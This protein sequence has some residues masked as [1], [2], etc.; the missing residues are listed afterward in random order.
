MIHVVV[1]S[2]GQPDTT[3]SWRGIKSQGVV[4][5]EYWIAGPHHGGQGFGAML[6]RV[7]V[8]GPE[9]V[10]LRNQMTQRSHDVVGNFELVCRASVDARS[11]MVELEIYVT[12][13]FLDP[14]R[15]AA[16]ALGS[17]RRTRSAGTS[18]KLV[19]KPMI[20]CRKSALSG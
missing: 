6:G 10:A 9:G 13:S 5:K 2:A 8:L 17:I 3:C 7:S 4:T 18:A 14:N 12:K 15:M 20:V 16:M 19:S 1:R 11:E